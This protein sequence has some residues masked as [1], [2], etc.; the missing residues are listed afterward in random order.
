MQISY[1]SLG[2]GAVKKTI[3][4]VALADNG[5]RWHLR[6]YDRQRARFA[7]FVLTRIDKVK[8]LDELATSN[9]RIEA[10]AQWN[11][12]IELHMLPHPGLKHPEAVVADYRMKNGRVTLNVSA[13]LAG[14]ALLRWAV[15]CSPDQSLDC[16]RHHLCL[17]DR[18]V[19]DGVDSAVLAPGFVVADG[20]AAP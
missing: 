2:S 8:A 6:A 9:E 7:D 16:A 18:S 3:V 14:Y 1:L 4:P 20:V 13:A 10:D 19:L 15:D 5:L 11:R 17:A 12:R